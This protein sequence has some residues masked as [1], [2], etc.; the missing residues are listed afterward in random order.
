M[1]QAWWVCVFGTCAR[2]TLTSAL[3]KTC[4]CWHLA[5]G[6]SLY[7]L[8]LLRGHVHVILHSSI[9]ACAAVRH[10]RFCACRPHMRL[11]CGC[12]WWPPMSIEQDARRLRAKL[13][14]ARVG[15]WPVMFA[16][17]AV[18]ARACADKGMLT[19]RAFVSM[20]LVHES[21]SSWV[22]LFVSRHIFFVEMLQ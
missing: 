20:G 1:C 2:A 18:S 3:P 19:I 21:G 17:T 5:F 8:P 13:L 12:R 4:Y 16:R 14:P 11:K 7:S 9:M 22:N 6:I 15:N 10:S